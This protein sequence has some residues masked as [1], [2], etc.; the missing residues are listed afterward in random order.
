MHSSAPGSKPEQ[1]S[2]FTGE[3]CAVPTGEA[4]SPFTIIIFGASGDLTARKIIPS[5]FHLYKSNNL[6]NPVQIVGVSRTTMSSEEYQTLLKETMDK[7]GHTLGEQWHNFAHLISY[8]PIEYDSQDSYKDLAQQLRQLDQEKSTR[9]NRIFYLATPPTLYASIAEQIGNAGLAVENSNGN[10]WSR[11]VVEKP[12]GRDLSSSEAL[13]ATLHH[14]FNEHQIYRIDHYLAKETVQNVLMLRFANTIFE[15]LWNRNH[16]SYI[17]IMA[18]EDLGVEHRAGY[19]EQSGVL[20]DMFQNHLHQL[21][22]LTALEPPSHFEAETVRD[23]KAKIFRS[24][25]P[26]HEETMFDNLI[27]G[28]YGPGTMNGQPVPGYREEKGVAPDSL[29]PTFA[30]MRVFIDN[31]RWRGVPFYLMSGKRLQR[32]ETKIVVQFKKVPHSMFRD[33]LGDRI[34]ANRLTLGIYPEENI[35]LAFQ[36]KSPSPHICLRPVNMDFKYYQGTEKQTQDAYEKVLLDVIQ[37]DHMLFWRRDGVGLS[38]SF[39]TP[40]LELC[41]TCGH[42]A[43]HLHTYPAGSWGP[44]KARQWARLLVDD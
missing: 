40:I 13:D 21:L 6:P 25:K 32:K 23:E 29:T 30:M 5:L 2:N 35:S 7:R 26:L 28:Q 37:G 9:G 15:P 41:E 19:Y 1:R 17:G 36:T 38:W 3:S 43:E 33:V 34:S 11:I 22:A 18:A 24:L 10:G 42:R 20:R 31:W 12:F 27:V 4:Q 14:S 44:E 8:I 39:L 16:V